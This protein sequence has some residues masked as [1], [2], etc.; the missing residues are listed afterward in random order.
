MEEIIICKCCNLCK[1]KLIF[2]FKLELINEIN[3]NN[4]L[5]IYYCESCNFY[6]SLSGNNQN[7]YNNYYMVFNNYKKEI[8][9]SDKNERCYMYLKEKLKNKNIK[10]ILDYGSGNCKIKNLLLD[11]YNVDNYDIGMKKNI[12]KYDCLLLSHVLE[13]IYDINEFIHEISLNIKDDNGLLYIEVPNAEYYD[14]MIDICPLQE[15]NIEHINFFSKYFL[16]KLLKKHNF[17]TISLED[18][19]FM[20]K[21]NKYYIIRAIFQK[22]KINNS[23]YKYIE[24]GNKIIKNY[25]FDFLKK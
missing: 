15:I 10:N 23:F 11:T 6:Y 13:H 1:V 19:Y 24:N 21:E 22:N 3:L 16:N 5:N 12:S 8:L 4:T 9:Y 14:E 25:N 18:D 20:I 7:D 17:I 2:N